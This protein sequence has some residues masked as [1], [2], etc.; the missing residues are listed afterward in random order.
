MFDPRGKRS[1]SLSAIKIL[2][3]KMLIGGSDAATLS[4][5]NYLMFLPS[6]LLLFHQHEIVCW[7]KNQIFTSSEWRVEIENWFNCIIMILIDS[8]FFSNHQKISLQSQIALDRYQPISSKEKANRKSTILS[9]EQA[10]VFK[11]F[12][13]NTWRWFGLRKCRYL[14]TNKFI[15]YFP[16]VLLPKEVAANVSDAFW[17]FKA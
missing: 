10:T 5:A 9:N 16:T 1:S 13:L 11:K 3:G 17:K 6:R 4:G 12:N 2:N 15:Y 14:F 7:I 8:L